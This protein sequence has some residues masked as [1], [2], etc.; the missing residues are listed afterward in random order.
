MTIFNLIAILLWSN[1][2]FKLLN[3]YLEQ[4]KQGK[5]PEFHRSMMPEI[6]KDIECWE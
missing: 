4:R 6:E 5:N 1:K 2:A 3:N